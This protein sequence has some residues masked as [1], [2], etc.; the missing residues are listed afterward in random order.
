[1]PSQTPRH[2]PRR[3]A[4]ALLGIGA[5][6]FAVS[7]ISGAY[8]PSAKTSDETRTD[9]TGDVTIDSYDTSAGAFEPATRE[10][11]AKN[12]PIPRKP[13]RMNDKSAR[14]LYDTIAYI[15]AALQYMNSTGNTKLYDEVAASEPGKAVI[16]GEKDER[17]F[18]LMREGRVWFDN[19]VA[20]VVLKT[21]EPT[22]DGDT[23]TWEGKTT[24]DYGTFQ[25]GEKETAD[26]SLAK[27]Y[28]V[29]QTTF[30]AVHR[31][32]RWWCKV[33]VPEKIVGS[34]ER[35]DLFTHFRMRV[36]DLTPTPVPTPEAKK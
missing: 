25:V 2:V 4:L 12:V 11:P 27:R 7:S 1:M 22:I 3:L 30:T 32:G 6:G 17:A 16:R 19:P 21:S 18:S 29:A 34:P 5:A 8:E 31:Q 23:Y 35:T 9:F 26:V 20:T 13:E 36:E 10:H 15:S 14:G 33:T 24:L 28:E